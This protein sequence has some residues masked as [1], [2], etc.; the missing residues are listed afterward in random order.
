M[1][2]C[3]VEDC[4]RRVRTRGY[5]RTHYERVRKTGDPGGPIK[6][7][8]RTN[9]EFCTFDGCEEPYKANGYCGAH[10]GQ[11]YRGEE[12]RPLIDRHMRVQDGQKRCNRCE[13]VLPI[14][15]FA[16]DSKQACGYANRCRTCTKWDKQWTHYRLR[17]HEWE[18]IFEAQG[19]VCAICKKDGPNDPRGWHTDHSHLCCPG[20]KSCGECVR[21]ICCNDCNARLIAGYEALPFEK[22]T[23]PLMNE[24]LQRRPVLEMRMRGAARDVDEAPA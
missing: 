11:W 9:P 22:Q 20:P 24:Y 4:G 6:V 12:L 17:Q 3:K 19:R 10:Y 7:I 23:W 14:V 2:I 5:C 21:G 13:K 15:N 18:A 16:K 8:S 1:T